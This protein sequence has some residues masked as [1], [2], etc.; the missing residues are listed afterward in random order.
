MQVLEPVCNYKMCVILPKTF[1]L[2]QVARLTQNQNFLPR[3]FIYFVSTAYFV[4]LQI[5]R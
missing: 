5:Y 1:V 3:V 4:K 2:G